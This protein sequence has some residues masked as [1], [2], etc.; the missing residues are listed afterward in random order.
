MTDNNQEKITE[1]EAELEHCRAEN[2]AKSEFLSMVTHQLR[3]PLSGIKWTFKMLLDGDLGSFTDEQRTIIEKGSESNERMLK[4]LQEIIIANQN[5]S[6]DFQYNTQPSD[7]QK[8]ISNIIPEFLESARS[9]SI[10]IK[11]NHPDEPLPLVTVDPEKISIVFQNLLENAVKY[12]EDGDTITV[13]FTVHDDSISISLADTGLGIP[14]DAQEYIFSKFFR[15]DNVKEIKKEGTGLG[16]FTA[17]NIVEKHNGSIRFE[18]KKNE[19][20]TFFITLPLS[21]VDK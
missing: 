11:I 16:L 17:K 12:S 19:G 4:L 18:S 15:A 13:N 5:E 3:T 2:K 20:T 21:T 7:M 10:D 14:D 9:K 8:I 1:L 6:W